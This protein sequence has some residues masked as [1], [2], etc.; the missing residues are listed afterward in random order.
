MKYFSL[1]YLF[2]SMFF[3]QISGCNQQPDN[4]KKEI[5]LESATT[6]IFV[7]HAEKDLTVKGDPMLTKEGLERAEYLSKFL[8]DIPVTAVYSSDYHRTRQTAQPTAEA[9]GLEITI[10]NPREIPFH[11]EEIFSQHPKGVILVV[12]HSNSTP[13]FINHIL[14][15]TKVDPIDETDYSN[16]FI[17]QASEIG[18][19][20]F[21][22]FHFGK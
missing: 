21:M 4:L 6:L 10:Y 1:I 18:T 8:K 15:E 17:V 19:A 9:N 14:G 11:A 7:R 13:N 22:H 3:L 12:G 20:E 2:T 16:I 5:L